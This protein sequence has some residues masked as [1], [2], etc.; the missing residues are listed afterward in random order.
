MTDRY[1][2]FLQVR[3]TTHDK[4]RIKA[5]AVEA[6]LKTSDYVRKRARGERVG[7]QVTG[8]RPGGYYP[9]AYSMRPKRYEGHP[10]VV[11]AR[12]SAE[13][14]ASGAAGETLTP[15]KA[16]QHKLEREQLERNIHGSVGSQE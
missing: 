14:D 7:G 4:E 1:D 6:G 15:E 9:T 2:A 13:L 11:E 8:G 16:L 3:L 12:E 5:R 10:A